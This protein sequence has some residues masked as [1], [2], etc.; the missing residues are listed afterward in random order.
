MNPH[1]PETEKEPLVM[2]EAATRFVNETLDGV[3]NLHK[4]EEGV[5]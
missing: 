1:I 3:L 5:L 2:M 4:L